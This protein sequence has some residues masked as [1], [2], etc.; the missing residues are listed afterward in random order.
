M[1]VTRLKGH[2]GIVARYGSER[3]FTLRL[4]YSWLTLTMLWTFAWPLLVLLTSAPGVPPEKTPA[5]WF[6]FRLLA[7]LLTAAAAGWIWRLSP[8]PTTTAD[9]GRMLALAREGRVWPQVL[10][11][12]IGLPLVLSGFLL[13]EDAGGALK[14]ASLALAEA[15]VIQVILSGYLHGAF[16][17]LLPEGRPELPAVGLYAL[18]FGIRGAL[19]AAA[20]ETLPQGELLLAATGGIL[21]GA[22]IGCLSVWLRARSGSILPGILSLWLLFLLIDLGDFYEG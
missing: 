19:A 13:A 21:A 3:S 16:D 22:L 18:T 4:L 14:L 17:L 2:E 20:E 8:V 11:F 15:V 6:Q 7:P 9:R 5:G 1:P 10:L 12:L